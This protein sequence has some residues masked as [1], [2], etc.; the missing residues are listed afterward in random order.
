VKIKQSLFQA[1]CKD[2][3]SKTGDMLSP[4]ECMHRVV[5]KR[6]QRRSG[7]VGELELPDPC[8]VTQA[9]ITEPVDIVIGVFFF[10]NEGYKDTGL[11]KQY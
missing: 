10:R 5:H 3:S 11:A 1:A 4:D 7:A 2:V 9:S 8:E 6:A